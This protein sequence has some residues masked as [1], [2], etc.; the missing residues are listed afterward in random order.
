M[1][2]VVTEARGT[3]ASMDGEYIVMHWNAARKSASA[4]IE[5]RVCVCVTHLTRKQEKE[6][7]EKKTKG[8]GQ[9]QRHCKGIIYMKIYK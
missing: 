8:Q 1:H 3:I 5:V 7:N 4:R 2:P 6:E 9:R